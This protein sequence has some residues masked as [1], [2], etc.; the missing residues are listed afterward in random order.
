M[1]VSNHVGVR[2]LTGRRYTDLFRS[3]RELSA[4]A[5]TKQKGSKENQIMILKERIHVGTLRDKKIKRS[6][7]ETPG[8]GWRE[9][10]QEKPRQY[11][12]KR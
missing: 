8:F 11:L 4:L 3:A 7:Q 1:D 12:H 2:M 5:G 6:D 10:D 9:P